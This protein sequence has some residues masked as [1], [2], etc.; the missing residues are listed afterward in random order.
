ME[1]VIVS[2]ILKRNAVLAIEINNTFRNIF[3]GNKITPRLGIYM[4]I[5]YVYAYV[6]CTLYQSKTENKVNA[7][8]EVND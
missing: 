2:A 3:H 1:M 6:Y 7:P 5:R 8:Q 4:F